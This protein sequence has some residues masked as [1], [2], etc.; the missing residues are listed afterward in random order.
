MDRND[1]QHDD[2]CP[3]NGPKRKRPVG[4]NAPQ[5][6]ASADAAERFRRLLAELIARQIVTER[7]KPAAPGGGDG[8]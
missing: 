4:A 6:P 5:G 1:F 8:P 7:Q 2:S 3:R